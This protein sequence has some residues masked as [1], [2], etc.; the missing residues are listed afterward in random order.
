MLR[1]LIVAALLAAS[2]APLGADDAPPVVVAAAAPD[3]SGDWSGYWE[4]GK[5]GHRGPLRATFTRVGPNCYQVRFAGRFAKVIPFR[6]STP[7]TVVGGGDGVALLSAS[8]TLG[9]V[10]G[11]FS[12][13]ATATATTFDADFTA[14]G[15]H[16]KFVLTRDCGR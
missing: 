10:L 12:M 9:P 14:R 7:L 4:S 5:N 1:T 2:V 16:G 8:K 6:Y 13:S 11:T 15:D 3:L